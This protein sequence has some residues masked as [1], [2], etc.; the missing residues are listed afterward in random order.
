MRNFYLNDVLDNI[1]NET[2]IRFRQKH[3]FALLEGYSQQNGPLDF[4]VSCYFRK[5]SALGS[6]DRAFIN[7]TIY[8]LIRWQGLLDFLLEKQEI[9]PSWQKRFEL[10][11]ERDPKSYIHDEQIPENVRLSIPL[12]LY[13]ELLVSWGKEKAHEIAL[14]CNEQAPTMVRINPLKTDRDT[15]FNKWQEVGFSVYLSQDSPYG[16]GFQKKINFFSLPEFK[17]G[18]FE[19]QDEASQMVALLLQAKPDD[20]VLDFCAGSGGKALAFAPQMQGKGQIYLHDI[21]K[22]ALIDAKKRLKRAGIQNAQ[23][24]HSDEKKRLEKLKKKMD[25]VFVDAPCSGTGTLRRNPDMKWKFS[26]KM[27]ARLVGEQRVIFEQALSYLKPTGKIIYATCSILD[28]ENGQ[29][30]NHFLKTYPIKLLDAPFQSIPFS[31]SKDGF[32]AACFELNSFRS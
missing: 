18:F 11:S 25:W 32:F 16:I 19:V 8:R 1:M 22:S 24:V 26:E 29:Q 14:A 10:L 7:E 31:H 27:V 2:S 20:Q 12:E 17:A 5:N 28:R 9:H 4:W 3:L 15:L 23:V 30:V 6:K 21:R 13:Q